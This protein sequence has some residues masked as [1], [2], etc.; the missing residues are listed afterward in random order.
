MRAADKSA[1]AAGEDAARAQ[2]IADDLVSRRP[3]HGPELD[4][5]VRDACDLAKKVKAH[6]D[7]TTDKGRDAAAVSARADA[8]A[9]RESHRSAD[10]WA[11]DATEVAD[12]YPH[13]RQFG[14]LLEDAGNAA[15]NAGDDARTAY[16]KAEDAE[17]A[18]K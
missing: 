10:R 6:R 5:A 12:A 9:A 2:A 8:R 13:I 4:V 17:D 11:R 3:R 15:A 14:P 18:D 7:V 16:A 1:R